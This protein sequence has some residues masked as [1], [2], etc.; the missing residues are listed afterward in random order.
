MTQ[1]PTEWSLVGPATRERVR[2][3]VLPFARLLSR[4][5]LSADALTVGGFVVSVGAAVIAASGAWLAAGVTVVAGALFDLFDGAVARVCGTTSRFG[6]FL[7]STLDRLGEAA[8]HIGIIAGL[9]GPAG[10][11]VAF[12][13]PPGGSPASTVAVVAA[14]AM[15][16]S[17]MVSYTHARA[18]GLGLEAAVGVAPRPERIAL[19]SIGLVLQPFTG[20]TLGAALSLVVVLSLVTVGQRIRHVRRTAGPD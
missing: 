7:D 11:A 14:A 8:V 6:G 2:D 16:A 1:R 12:P 18:G 9:L 4:A 15:A 3:A 20:W 19:L 13:A 5:G 17:L 10:T